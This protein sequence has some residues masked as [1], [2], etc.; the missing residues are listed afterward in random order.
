MCVLFV[1][2]LQRLLREHYC[3]EL[4][5]TQYLPTRTDK[6]CGFRKIYVLPK[7]V[8]KDH[9]RIENKSKEVN[10]VTV[11]TYRDIFTHNNDLCRNV[12][13]VGE[14]GSGKSSFSQHIALLW[15]EEN[16]AAGAH[17]QSHDTK[18]T[19]ID[20]IQEFEFVFHVKLRDAC[21]LCDLE[22]II[23][24]QLLSRLDTDEID[25]ANSLVKKVLNTSRCLILAD[26]RDEW[27]HPETCAPIKCTSEEKKIAP[28]IHQRSSAT[29]LFTSRPVGFTEFSEHKVDNYLEIEGTQNVQQ[30]GENILNVLNKDNGTKTFDEFEASVKEKGLW[31][32]LSPSPILFIQMICLWHDN[33]ELSK[34]VSI[35]YASIFNM[36][37][38][39]AKVEVVT[40]QND[41]LDNK[42]LQIITDMDNINRNWK[43]FKELCKLAFK[44]LFAKDGRSAVVFSNRDCKDDLKTFAVKC[45][46]L[47]E[48]K[49]KSV[50]S[51]SHHLSFQHKT[52]Q[53]FLASVH[54]SLHDD[55]LATDIEPRYHDYYGYY[56]ARTALERIFV[57]ICALNG[58]TAQKMSEYLKKLDTEDYQRLISK[59]FR[60]A[61]NAGNTN[62]ELAC[63]CTIEIVN[64]SGTD[65]QDYIGWT[66]KNQSNITDVKLTK[67]KQNMDSLF[68]FL[69]TL[70][71]L[72]IIHLVYMELDIKLQLPSSVTTIVLAIVIVTRG[73]FL[74]H[75]TQLQTVILVSMDLEHLQLQLPSSVTE[76][77]LEEVKLT[78][79]DFLRHLTQLKTVRLSSMDLG[80]LLLQLPSS[81]TTIFLGEVKLTRGDCLHHVTQLQTVRLSNIDLGDILLQLP[82][83]VTVIDL[84]KVKMT[85]GDFLRH[86]TQLQTV[87]LSNIDL[88]DLLLQLPSSVTDIDLY[89]VKLTN[90][91]FLRHLTQLQT[92]R[93]SSMDLGDLLLQLP[94]SVID[95]SLDEVKLTRGDCLHHLSQLQTVK[96]S[97]I[98]LG[99]FRMQLPSSVTG[100]GLYKVKLTNGDFLRH[101][102][103]LQT[104]KLECMDL[105][106]LRLQLP[107]SVTAIELV[108]VTVRRWDFLHHLTQLQKVKQSCMD[109][110]DL[111]LPPSVT[112]VKLN[113]LTGSVE[114]MLRLAESLEQTTHDVECS[115]I[116]CSISPVDQIKRVNERLQQSTCL[117]LRHPF[118][119]DSETIDSV[120][121]TLYKCKNKQSRR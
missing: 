85:N 102:T 63:P 4:E 21:D 93:L 9:R 81:V 10:G 83:S 38:G 13:V 48:K 25:N 22:E 80:D 72:K 58:N 1:S 40:S 16:K 47:T 2:E 61:L 20:T 74:R 27:S 111:Q 36:L 94:S 5:S 110:G 17:H 73:D 109:L 114:A 59:G 45:G 121:F 90:G 116:K 105:G 89:K 95:I 60:E 101:L 70:P 120:S 56:G 12:F 14:A 11:T 55:L 3:R 33:H 57:F 41:N 67:Y 18:F 43:Q 46:I 15:S 75:L 99:E 29:V 44:K 71:Q 107:S 42:Q 24:D 31:D 64:P 119:V 77:D 82:S 35:T 92:V 69:Q 62:I 6:Y 113:K 96:L 39:R 79:G 30:L 103:Q 115:V 104:V 49:S 7:L 37:I 34:S 112:R 87:T 78:N 52:F 118:K 19:D 66:E 32:N 8:K 50:S 98:D 53:E 108:K 54:L 26:G 28:L 88:G 65:M 23:R 86:V 106:D 100:I 76:I 84:Y 117:K 91:D 68:S 51:N 97:Y